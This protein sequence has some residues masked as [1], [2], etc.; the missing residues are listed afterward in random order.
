MTIRL[1]PVL[2]VLV[3]CSA[4][5]A[6]GMTVEQALALRS[7]SN[8]QLGDDFVAFSLAV[9]R[10]LDDGAGGAYLHVAVID[11]LSGL[12]AAALPEPRWLVAGKKS[13]STL[14]VRP[15]HR[16]ISFR[17]RVS[18]R[19]QVLVQSID[20]GRP[21]AWR[22]T[23]SVAGYSWR[24]DGLTLAFTALDPLPPP[25]AE[26]EGRGIAPIVVDED[27]RHLSLWTVAGTGEPRQL[28][29]GCT[30][31]DFVWSPDGSQLA[32]AIAPRNL[33]DDSYMSKSLWLVDAATGER[34]LLVDNRGK[35]GAFAWAPDGGSI[36][37]VSAA[38]RNDPHA[39]MLYSVAVDSGEVSAWTRGLRGMIEG[40]TAT[41]TGFLV[42][43]S[44]GVRTRL[45]HLDPEGRDQWIY[46]AKDARLAIR[47]VSV[48]GSDFVFA[49]S[50]PTHPSELWWPRMEG[51][52]A[53]ARRLTDSNPTL[54]SV[55]LGRQRVVR[56][57]ARDG[58]P[59][60]GLLIEPVGHQEGQRHPLVIVVH[61]GPES[62][63][64]D[65]WL[66]SYS[67]WGQLLAAR[68]YAVWMPNYRASTGYGVE[69]CK[70]DHGDPMGKEFEDHIDAIHHLVASGI[71]DRARVGIGGGSY[72]G[73]TAAWAA[74]RHS[75]HFAA[76]VSFVP[77]VDIR[78]KWLTSDIPMEFYYV[79][80]QEKWPW[81]Q[82]GLL[83]D[84]SPLSWAESCDT[85][86]L[87]LG[88][89]RDTRVH[90]SQPFML[91][92]A[93]K[94][95]TDT[96]VRYVQYPGE[97]HGNRTNVYRYD[98]ALRALRWFDHYVKGDGDRRGRALPPRDLDYGGSR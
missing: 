27:Y 22:A 80:Y 31:F 67:N 93:V 64:H 59:I 53:A 42:Q 77:F 45:R 35:L 2:F 32:C 4:V 91:Y 18:G 70:Q 30:V 96:P 56:F 39:G 12:D 48:R 57:R 7:V 36:A 46:E 38:D 40:V 71:A 82:P 23:P 54:S 79:H 84:R 94:F 47:D 21:M 89:T 88:G 81:Q 3:V 72:G 66:T 55:E 73:Y 52:S 8:P 61:G 14:R 78:T 33:V 13:A 60:E 25:R 87:L 74:T 86:L 75:E 41:P 28:T 9:P 44:L 76:A 58:L 51:E 6:Q 68:G 69:F 65:G 34:R 16:E 49:A 37:F 92:R 62:H 17:G 97:G 95:A 43:E 90:P 5:V 24:G 98:Y 50:S 20:D 11:G 19:M 1:T 29:S 15:G 26:A 63:F 83:A 85:P 10:P